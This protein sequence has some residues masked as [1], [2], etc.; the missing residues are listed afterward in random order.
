MKNDFPHLD[1]PESLRRQIVELAR[2]F[3]K[4]PTKSEHILWQALRGKKLDRIKFRKSKDNKSPCSKMG[5]G[6]GGG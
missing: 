6:R 3:R 5:Q 2:Q 4:R 1:V